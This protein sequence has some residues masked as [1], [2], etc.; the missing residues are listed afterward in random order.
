MFAQSQENRS[1]NQQIEVLYFED[2][3]IHQKSG[4]LLHANTTDIEISVALL[5]R[6][7]TPRRTAQISVI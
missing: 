6:T 2:V 7:K 3:F 1:I 5:R 4:F